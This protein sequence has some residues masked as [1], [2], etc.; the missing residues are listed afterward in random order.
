MSIRL[1]DRK[2][3]KV[4]FITTAIDIECKT[5]AFIL[6]MSKK[7]R[8]FFAESIG[9]LVI[10][11][12]S[13]CEM[14]N[15]IFPNSEERIAVREKHLLEAKGALSALDVQLRFCYDI[16]SENP[17][18][19]FESS[20]GNPVE[21]GNASQK[22]NKIAETLGGLIVDEMKLIDGVIKSDKE[23]LKNMKE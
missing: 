17:A 19:G 4:Q 7:Y 12:V 3:S 10:D 22:L 9:K 13:N 8:D 21:K 5:I 11:L 18:Y 23:K 2:E 1:R 20:N 15:S 6:R 14:A 16:I